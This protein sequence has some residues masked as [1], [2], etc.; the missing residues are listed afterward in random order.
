MHKWP[1]AIAYELLGLIAGLKKEQ[2][3]LTRAMRRALHLPSRWSP[4]VPVVGG[5]LRDTILVRP[6][7]SPFSTASAP[8]H[9][10]LCERPSTHCRP[11]AT[12]PYRF[13]TGI[14]TRAPTNHRP[15][16]RPA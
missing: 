12:R 1:G 3:S 6:L 7:A 15:L 9:P 8:V 14:H 11:A 16:L 5:P 2:S 4:V 13:Q 10:V